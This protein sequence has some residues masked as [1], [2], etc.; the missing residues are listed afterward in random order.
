MTD[1]ADNPDVPPSRRLAALLGLPEPKPFDEAE[2]RA[3][4]QWLADGDAQ[5]EALLARRRQ[6]AA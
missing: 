5:V 2:E 3:Y 1:D 4:Q 6:R